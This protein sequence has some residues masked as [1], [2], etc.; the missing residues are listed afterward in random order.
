MP[1]GLIGCGW[2]GLV[3]TEAGLSL[4]R[5]RLW[6]L[7]PGLAA[8]MVLH[9]S[10]EMIA[11][12]AEAAAPHV[13]VRWATP[14]C[15]TQEGGGLRATLF[16]RMA[17][18]GVQQRKSLLRTVCNAVVFLPQRSLVTLLKLLMYVA[19][20][21]FLHPGNVFALANGSTEVHHDLRL[22]LCSSRKAPSTGTDLK[23]LASSL[24]DLCRLPRAVTA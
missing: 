1:D 3:S 5:L 21:L 8:L 6:G 19:C 10:L 17:W 16:A 12:L 14:P 15:A 2:R 24:L 9:A 22:E 23:R 20:A 4:D 13:F 18:R 11:L 7:L